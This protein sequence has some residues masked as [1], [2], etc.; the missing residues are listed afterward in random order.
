V[1]QVAELVC[2]VTVTRRPLPA[3]APPAAD[4]AP[5]PPAVEPAAGAP[6]VDARRIADLV[7]RM[8]RDDL[9]ILRERS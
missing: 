2:R 4:I 8:M 7:Y 5:A 9:A 1:I 3:V 6:P